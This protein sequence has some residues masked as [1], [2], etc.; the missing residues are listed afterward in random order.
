MMPFGADRIA[1]TGRADHAFRK[2]HASGLETVVERR[3]KTPAEKPGRSLREQKLGR[4]MGAL[5]S[6]PR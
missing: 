3:G 6:D 4:R 2:H 5:R 1:F